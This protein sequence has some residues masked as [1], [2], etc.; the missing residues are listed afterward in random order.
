MPRLSPCRLLQFSLV[1]GSDD[2]RLRPEPPARPIV[3]PPPAKLR[4]PRSA[5]AD[6]HSSY[7]AARSRLAAQAVAAELYAP[8]ASSPAGPGDGL[9]ALVNRLE[10]PISGAM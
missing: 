3:C 8:G 1:R 6:R 10:I 2:A 7:P 5:E 9:P 4:C